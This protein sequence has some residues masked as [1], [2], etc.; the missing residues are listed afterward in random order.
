MAGNL[1]DENGERNLNEMFQNYVS[2]PK[3]GIEFIM[4]SLGA[5]F[6][7]RATPIDDAYNA[8]KALHRAEEAEVKPRYLKMKLANKSTNHT[9]N[10]TQNKT[11]AV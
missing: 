8:E 9:A 5:P 6:A 7:K 4:R 1:C 2:K 10:V 11:A 3:K